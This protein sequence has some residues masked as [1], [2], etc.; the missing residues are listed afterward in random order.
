MSGCSLYTTSPDAAPPAG[1]SSAHCIHNSKAATSGHAVGKRQVALAVPSLPYSAACCI[2]NGQGVHRAGVLKQL[3]SG[4]PGPSCALPCPICLSV[5]LHVSRKLLSA[6]LGTSGPS[7]AR[8]IAHAVRPATGICARY[9]MLPRLYS[10][11]PGTRNSTLSRC[12]NGH[13][14]GS[15]GMNRSTP[16]V[17]VQTPNLREG[18]RTPSAVERPLPLAPCLILTMRRRPSPSEH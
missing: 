10:S 3:D 4:A 9:G 17:A 1:S 5:R 6:S 13:P 11:H 7:S 15:D 18:L 14:T 12:A 16:F 2:I 8:A